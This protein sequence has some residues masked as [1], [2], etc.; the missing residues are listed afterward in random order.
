MEKITCDYCEQELGKEHIKIGSTTKTD[1]TYTNN[2]NM[3]EIVGLT[4]LRNYSD[5]HFC[6]KRHFILYFFNNEQTPCEHAGTGVKPNEDNSCPV[7]GG[8]CQPF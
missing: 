5:L 7:C 6:S 1:L 2:L 3:S 4:E 8:Y